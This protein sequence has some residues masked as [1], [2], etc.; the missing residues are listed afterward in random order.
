MVGTVGLVGLL[1][2]SDVGT[3]GD[4]GDEGVEGDVFDGLP[5]AAV[6]PG[7]LVD[8][9]LLLLD[10]FADFLLL[11]PFPPLPLLLDRAR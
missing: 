3:E 5:G 10:P 1:A 8:G 2:P 9:A 7:A 11:V 6:L 4:E